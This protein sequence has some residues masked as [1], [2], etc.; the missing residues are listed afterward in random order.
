[1][2]MMGRRLTRNWYANQPVSFRKVLRVR[3][4][5]RVGM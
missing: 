3:D 1:M 2:V 5:E 4:W